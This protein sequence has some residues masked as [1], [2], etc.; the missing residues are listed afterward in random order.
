M[1]SSSK[2]N[3]QTFVWTGPWY[4]N[5]NNCRYAELFKR[6]PAIDARYDRRSDHWLLRAVMARLDNLVLW[7]IYYPSVIRRLSTRYRSL[8]CTDTRQIPLFNG[9]IIVDEDDPVFSKRNILLWNHPRVKAIVTTSYLL[10]NQ[11]CGH[12]IQKTC[13]VI[14]SGVDISQLQ[15][16]QRDESRSGLCK[17]DDLVVGFAVP[18]LYTDMD[19][20]AR[21]SEGQLRSISNLVTIMERVWTKYPNMQLWLLGEPSRSVQAYARANSRV[22]TWG[23]INHANIF[24]YYRCFDIA[25]YPRFVNFG[26]RHSIKLVEYLSCG[27]PVVSTNVCEAYHVTNS[28]GGLI[29]ANINEFVEKILCLASDSLLRAKLADAGVKYGKLFDWDALAQRYMAEI[30][31][32]V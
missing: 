7:R 22:K 20:A 9:N 15:H 28:G 14:P 29:A 19:T 27:I 26:G 17:P 16:Y 24:K 10:R 1:V 6:L 32:S 4:K 8:F 5:H 12:G 11:F 21:S 31:N 13:H 25:V 30:L 2:H 3:R 23:Y 18:C